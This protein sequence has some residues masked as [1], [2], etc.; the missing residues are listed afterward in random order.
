M[1]KS[2]AY[3]V[4]G[5]FW[6]S[7]A[8][9]LASVPAEAAAPVRQVS[10]KVA[11]PAKVERAKAP[12]PGAKASS[13]LV[14]DKS[15]KWKT[16]PKSHSVFAVIGND[17]LWFI[18]PT[19]G[20]PYSVDKRGYV[21]TA[22][23]WTGAVY[24]LGR[25]SS[26]VGDALYFFGFW[27]FTDGNYRVSDFNIYNTIYVDT[28]LGFYDYDVA[29]SEVWEYNEY[30]VS[31][32]FSET[33]IQTDYYDQ[34]AAEAEV[35][36][37]EADVAEAEAAVAEA[38]A[39]SAEADATAA[40]A[41]AASAEADAKSAEA[42]AAEAEA[43][44]AAAEADADASQADADASEADAAASEAGD[45]ASDADNGDEAEE[46]DDEG[47]ADDGADADDGDAGDADE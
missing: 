20:W 36:A 29:Y 37:A 8:F 1:G 10:M 40:E 14:F 24:D 21:F 43:D 34:V 2:F 41:E 19:S 47:D 25:L 3:L 16:D 22:N 17:Q 11:T 32:E 23:P 9:A 44:A 18:D 30:F 15:V 7:A 6:L 42:D 5:I 4:S 45:A 13:G 38:D 26:W 27:D 35:A 46:A 33:T 39:A 31:T 12:P 28:S